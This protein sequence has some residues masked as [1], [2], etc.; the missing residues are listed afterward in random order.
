M[1][2]LRLAGFAISHATFGVL[3]HEL[4][5]HATSTLGHVMPLIVFNIFAMGLEGMVSFIQALRLTFYELFTKFFS[6]A[7]RRFIAIRDL[8]G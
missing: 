7:G 6:A 4:A 5:E 2:F 8:L 1:S 3:A